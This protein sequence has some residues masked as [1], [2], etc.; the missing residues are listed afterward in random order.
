M[1][2]SKNFVLFD[3]GVC[4]GA[5]LGVWYA[6]RACAPSV[7]CPALASHC[8][9][10]MYAARHVYRFWGRD[11]VRSMRRGDIGRLWVECCLF[12]MVGRA[13]YLRPKSRRC[14]AVGLRNAPAGAAPAA[15]INFKKFSMCGGVKT[16]PYKP[17]QTTDFPATP[18]RQ[19]TPAGRHICLPYK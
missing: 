10:R 1:P 14:A 8:R 17:G 9:G 18:A 7:V 13:I 16:P 6:I 19:N 5:C 12:C 3:F 15:P 2:L 11:L 4:L